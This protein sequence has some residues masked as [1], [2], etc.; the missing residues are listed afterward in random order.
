MRLPTAKG[1]EENKGWEECNAV[2]GVEGELGSGWDELNGGYVGGRGG[3]R[4]N[5]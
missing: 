1:V 3:E 2:G 4:K 5:G